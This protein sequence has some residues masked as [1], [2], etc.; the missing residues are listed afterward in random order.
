MKLIKSVEV[1]QFRSLAS[2]RLADLGDFTAIAGLNSSGKSNLLRALN[3]YFR[4]ETDPGQPIDVDSDHNVHAPARKKRRIRIGASFALSDD[5][6]FRKGLEDA[7][8]YLGSEFKITK[9]WTRDND[10]PTYY[11]N[12]AVVEVEDRTRID[13]FL[14]L[15]NFRYIPNRVL[16]LDVIRAENRQLRDVIIK[17]LA[18]R[19]AEQKPVFQ[20]L[21][22]TSKALFTQLEAQV[23]SASQH[24]E[25]VRLATPSS[26]QDLIFAFGYRLGVNGKELDDTVQGSGI[27]SLL[28]LATLALIDCDYKNWFGWKQA[29]IW[30]FEEPES[31][32]HTLLEARVASLLA[33]LARDSRNRLQITATTH[34]DIVLQHA[35]R[36]SLF[37]MENGVTSVAADDR[38]A[39][40]RTSATFG[41]TRWVHPILS[42]PLSPLLLVEGKRDYDFLQAA[43]NVLRPTRQIRVA[44]LGQLNPDSSGGVDDLEK[45]LAGAKQALLTRVPEAPVTVLLDW[46][47]DNKRT[48]FERILSDRSRL[49]VEVWPVLA[50]NPRLG[51]SFRGI[52]RSFSDRLID[53]ASRRRDVLATRADG[54]LV[55]PNDD[56]E[57]FKAEL[58]AVVRAG[59]TTDD[60]IHCRAFLEQLLNDACRVLP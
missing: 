55:V 16:P 9:E 13:Q 54:T 50:L 12:D 14:S 45:Y 57:S 46:D 21:S 4:G 39:V 10:R 36:T 8:T 56:R 32:L 29:T 43:F 17:R 6:K 59:I 35:D 60:L 2:M 25:S 31:S 24:L 38:A 28:M 15:I 26:W 42:F 53:A 18:T 1:E 34:S 5:F 3:A 41:V 49:R 44:Y 23:R 40:L 48:R 47:A 7:K 51:N 19:V 52:E 58:N 30:A 22:Q 27:Q 37:A 20:Q 11:L 33:E